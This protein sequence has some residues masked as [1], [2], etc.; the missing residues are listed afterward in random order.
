MIW[1]LS[2]LLMMGPL[3]G[4]VPAERQQNDLSVPL[5]SPSAVSMP[6]FTCHEV[7]SS[8]I[9]AQ[10]GQPPLLRASVRRGGEVFHM[11]LIGNTLNSVTKAEAS[12]GEA[13]G[14]AMTVLSNDTGVVVA[15][16]SD[17]PGSSISF[18]LQ[19]QT[20]FALWTRTR[21]TTWLGHNAPEIQ[22]VY[23]ACR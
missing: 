21:A 5:P 1:G 4:V 15:T 3:Q 12:I 9:R 10:R 20:G 17:S 2:L 8:T 13:E 6:Q 22:A 7:L 16:G 18:V 14:H 19:R 11:R 23:F